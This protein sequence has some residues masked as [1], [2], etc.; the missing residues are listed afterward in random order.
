MFGRSILTTKTKN[1]IIL[2]SICR[3][4][5][6]HIMKV[7]PKDMSKWIKNLIFIQ[8][9]WR[10][11][12]IEIYAKFLTQLEWSRSRK[13]SSNINEVL[14]SILP[15]SYSY[16]EMESETTLFIYKKMNL[17]NIKNSPQTRINL[18]WLEVWDCTR[19]SFHSCGGL[20]AFSHLIRALQAL[21]LMKKWIKRTIIKSFGVFGHLK[22]PIQNWQKN[23]HVHHQN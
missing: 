3:H 19:P 8:K 7:L 18:K 21:W 6:S 10:K 11:W 14:S 4:L 15:P 12:R 22:G 5:Q 1:I 9:W 16:W 2:S 20:V 13:T 17:L 23:K